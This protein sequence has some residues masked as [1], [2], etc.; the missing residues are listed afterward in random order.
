MS[1]SRFIKAENENSN[2]DFSWKITN[3]LFSALFHE[4]MGPYQQITFC[5]VIRFSYSVILSIQYDF[6]EIGSSSLFPFEF[7]TNGAKM[8]INLMF[9]HECLELIRQNRNNLFWGGQ[10][11]G[12]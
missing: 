6:S 1:R 11:F 4:G 5:S 3:C 9:E 8:A 10:P 2:N 7:K 12:L